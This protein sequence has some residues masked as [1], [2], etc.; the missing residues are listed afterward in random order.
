MNT[1]V[2][3]T[4]GPNSVCLYIDNCRFPNRSAKSCDFGKTWDYDHIGEQGF[5]DGEYLIRLR[6]SHYPSQGEILSDFINVGDLITENPIKPVFLLKDIQVKSDADLP[7]GTG[8]QLFL[9]GGS[10]PAYDSETWDS[11]KPMK[12]YRKMAGTENEWRFFQWKAILTTKKGLQTPSLEKVTITANI[13]ITEVTGKQPSADVLKN[14]NII[15]GYYNYAYQPY[16]DNRLKHLRE[17]FRLD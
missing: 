3:Y 6:L 13:D 7:P 16:D 15:R 10:T 11:W 8:I 9:R 14:R 2:V 4:T 12:E 17:Y 1:F 5:C